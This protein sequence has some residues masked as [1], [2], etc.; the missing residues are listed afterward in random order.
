M[1]E[2]MRQQQQSMQML[3]QLMAN[4]NGAAPVVL[5]AGVHPPNV[6][7]ETGASP[8]PSR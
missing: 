2:L 1:T 6:E 4:Q 8:A 5:P 7:L 3:I